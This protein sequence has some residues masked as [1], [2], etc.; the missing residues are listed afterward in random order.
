MPPDIRRIDGKARTIRELLQKARYSIDFY[1]REYAWEQRQ[2]HELLDDLTSKFLEFHDPGHDRTQVEHYGHYFL[3]SI[4][5]SHKHHQRFIV[6]GQQRLTSLTLLFIHLHHLAAGQPGVADVRDL[7]FSER[8][9]KKSF[10]L[11][12]PERVPCMERLLADEAF[13]PAGASD[14]VRNLVARYDDVREHLSEDVAGPALP[15]FVDWLLEN[16]HLVEIEAY[17]DADAYTI[18]ETMNDRGLSLSLP[19]MLK[20][21]LLAS[22]GDDDDQHRLN[23]LWKQ[24]MLEL[25]ALGAEEDVDFFKSWLRG[26]HAESARSGHRGGDNKDYERIGAEFHR[27]VR[28][29]HERIG[30]LKAADFIRFV[31]R[32]FDFYARQTVRIRTA[33]RT[34]VPGLEAIRF[35]EDRAFTMQTQVL[36]AAVEPGDP[37]AVVDRKLALVADYLDIW[38]ARRIWANRSVGQSSVRY[39]VFALTKEVRGKSVEA[40]SAHLRGLLDADRDT[41]ARHPEFVM[42][43]QNYRQ[44]RHVLARLT[45]WIDQQ[46]GYPCHFDDLVSEGKARPYEIEHVWPDKYA[47]FADWFRTPQEFDR[48]RNRIG[49]LVLLQRGHNQS[50]GDRPYEEKRDPYLAH[51]PM[52][53]RS[54]HPLAYQNNPAFRQLLERTQLP[55]RAHDG[56]APADQAER[57]VLYLRIAEWVW[58]PSRLDLDGEKPVAPE[59]IEARDEEDEDAPGS[60]G[61]RFE[62]RRRFWTQLVERARELQTLHAHLSPTPYNW[63]GTQKA[64]W[65]WNFVVLQDRLRVELYLD[66]PE[67]SA[68][69]AAFDQLYARRAELEAALGRPLEWQRLDN[70]RASR[71]SLGV[72]G[73]WADESTWAGAIAAGLEAM[74]R[75]H[76]VLAPQLPAGNAAGS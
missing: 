5:V 72:A 2:I 50:L 60:D 11:D 48:A 9:G 70:R 20:G 57:Q 25:R 1:Q 14:S 30:L 67:A 8:F 22:V 54:L 39:A 21:Y 12:V 44:V 42:H 52:L 69:K 53:T 76:Q 29:Q 66:R 73:G 16:V 27:W 13:D 75:L 36:L 41:F 6:D 45:L 38:L 64:G 56:F 35:N 59:P 51:G 65:W 37:P 34:L 68:N 17:S 19:D 24:R 49:G 63:L 33:A 71:V 7:I 23:A 62:A 40:L 31:E 32:D 58:N 18:F 15:F 26:R 46:C 28:E 4:V 10:N 47:R 3:G 43:Q 61:P 74:T 55:F